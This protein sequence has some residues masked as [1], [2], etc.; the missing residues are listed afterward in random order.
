MTKRIIFT[1]LESRDLHVSAGDTASWYY[2]V[3]TTPGEHAMRCITINGVECDLDDPKAYWVVGRIAGTCVGGWIPGHKGA[4]AAERE[5]G[6]PMG[7][8]VQVYA[9]AVR[10][11]IANGEAPWGC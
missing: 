2:T 1:E 11:R 7:A 9:Y 10:E 4:N 8:P 5:F 6:Q 3:R